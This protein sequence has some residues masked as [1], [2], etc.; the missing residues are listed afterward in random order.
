MKQIKYLVIFI[1]YITLFCY[2]GY[3]Q[4]YK[5]IY[6]NSNIPLSNIDELIRENCRSGI[7]LIN[8]TKTQ[9]TVSKDIHEWSHETYSLQY[10]GIPLE[11]AKLK[12]HRKDGQIILINGF[13]YD[14][15]NIETTPY[16]SES[17]ALKAA[18][19]YV[20][21][22]K[23]SWTDNDYR[24]GQY[25]NQSDSIKFSQPPV[26]ELVICPIY[27]SANERIPCL[28]FR[29]DIMS[30]HPFN[31]LS[32][33]IDAYTGKVVH[34]NS[35]VKYITGTAQTRYS[36]TQYIQTEY[37]NNSYYLHDISRGNGIYTYNNQF[38]YYYNISSATDL[39]DIDNNWTYSEYH[40]SNKRDAALDAHWGA[41][42]TYDYF[43]YVFARNS[44]DNEGMAIRNYINCL[45]GS[46]YNANSYCQA[47]WIPLSD[48]GYMTYGTGLSDNM[49]DAFTALDVIAHELGHGITDHT[50]NLEY[51]WE[52][53]AINEGISD[54]WAAC[55][56]NYANIG[57]NIWLMGDDLYGGTTATRNMSNP[58]QFNQP[59][60]YL[61]TGNNGYWAQYPAG[62]TPQEANDYC[63]VHTNSGVINYWFYL[64]SEGGEGTNDFNY[65]Y[66]VEGVGIENAAKIVYNALCNY[67]TPSTNYSQAALL[68][69]NSAVEL[70]GYCS[71]EFR[72]VV[73][74]WKAVGVGVSVDAIQETLNITETLQN[75]T[76]KYYYAVSN[77][78]TT[79]I[80]QDSA[81][82][83]Y[84]SSGSIVLAPGFSAEYGSFVLARII[85]C[86]EAN[87][88]RMQ[89]PLRYDSIKEHS[90]S[91]EEVKRKIS[92][93]PNPAR[94]KIVINGID[95]SCTY[96][97]YDA[98]GKISKVGILDYPYHINVAQLLQGTYILKVI[99]DDS[100]SF[101]KFLKQ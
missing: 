58:K 53:G 42:K 30:T 2:H 9:D 12:V 71:Q 10:K 24:M 86:D 94:D 20:G 18:L 83:I 6:I 23:Y 43:K 69:C 80:I 60:T 22:E 3:G 68:T 84:E 33:Y 70:Y 87:N 14:S 95:N 11:F 8:D 64:L 85:P 7:T 35:L 59:D 89:S 79:S 62:T 29:F 1:F 82:A 13:A 73:D 44:L 76:H 21:A 25:W 50:A 47:A 57:K 78:T 77:L 100:Y 27:H 67:F 15:I 92:I 38:N 61:S 37:L 5:D 63:G 34:T 31:Y 49:P 26:G 54:I 101:V 55:V 36:G 99:T 17:E 16:I 4:N 97:I 46:P 41:M 66:D 74:A 98:M 40:D 93:S 96:I 90:N 91:Y 51:S 32:V 81:S 72:S 45:F 48:G 19:G 65:H 39:V 88:N 52:S 28:T 56:E 75:G